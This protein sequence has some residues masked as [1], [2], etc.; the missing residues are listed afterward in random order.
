MFREAS[1]LEMHPDK[2]NNNLVPLT[3]KM[4]KDAVDRTYGDSLEVDG[5]EIWKFE[6]IGIYKEYYFSKKKH[7]IDIDDGTALS[8][9]C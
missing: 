5:I 9:R 7:Y 1:D 2:K 8:D 6:I 4:A 3:L